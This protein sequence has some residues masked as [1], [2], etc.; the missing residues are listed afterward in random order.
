MTRVFCYLPLFI[1]GVALAVFAKSPKVSPVMDQ[2]CNEQLQIMF[3]EDQASRRGE[4]VER[5]DEE[6]RKL[7]MAALAANEVVTPRDKLHAGYVLQHTGL[8]FC[9]D[10]FVSLSVENYLLAHELFKQ[11]FDAGLDGAGWLVAASID[12]YLSFTEGIQKYGTNRVVNQDTGDEE[13]I[14]IDR[15]V[16]DSERA[17]Y[18][19]PPL[20]ELLAKYPEQKR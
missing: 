14:P 16:P 13:L 18:G 3:N 12:R 4:D 6:R 9:N 17:K 11:A 8:A 10:E 1:L 2:A 19:V 5:T 15:D 7:V 20:A